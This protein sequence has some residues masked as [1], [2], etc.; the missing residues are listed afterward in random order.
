MEV[1]AVTFPVRM[2][3]AVAESD[4]SGD[5]SSAE[6]KSGHPANPSAGSSSPSDS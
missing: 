5:P 6:S 1:F 4:L 2:P 3:G